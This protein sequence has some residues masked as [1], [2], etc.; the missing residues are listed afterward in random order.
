MDKAENVGS[1]CCSGENNDDTSVYTKNDLL[2]VLVPFS[3]GNTTASVSNLMA[4]G[5]IPC[6][7]KPL[8]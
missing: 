3:V 2:L 1:N 5:T 4:T 8:A 7:H 6:P